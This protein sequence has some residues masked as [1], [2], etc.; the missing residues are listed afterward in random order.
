MAAHLIIVP[1]RFHD[2]DRSN[3]RALDVLHPEPDDRIGDR[4]LVQRDGLTAVQRDRLEGHDGGQVLALQALDQDLESLARILPGALRQ[5]AGDAVDEDPLGADL[6]CFVDEEAVGLPQFL[7]EDFA[8]REN[9]LELLAAFQ[10]CQV[11]AETGGVAHQLVGRY[12]EHHDDAGFAELLGAAVHELH[13]HRGL[14]GADLSLDQGDIAARNSAGK[15]PVE[16]ADA[17]SDTLGFGHGHP[18]LLAI[19]QS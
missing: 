16:P 10:L 13:P 1:A 9:D 15:N 11:P 6:V 7:P 8:R 4:L 18:Y 19:S 17:G 12:L 2:L 5:Q 3:R 14:A